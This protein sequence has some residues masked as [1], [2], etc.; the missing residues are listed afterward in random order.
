MHDEF[1]A[2]MEDVHQREKLASILTWI[3]TRYPQLEAVV[4][5]NQ[6]MFLDHGTFIIAFSVSKQHIAVAPEVIAMKQFELSIKEAG[7]KATSNLFRIKWNDAIAWDLL[8]EIITFNIE[9][10]ATVTSFWR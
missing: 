5:W 8:E 9:D 10:K 2:T 3:Q 4:K 6:P 1:L 7:Y